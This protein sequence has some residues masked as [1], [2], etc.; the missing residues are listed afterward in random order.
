MLKK[1]LIGASLALIAAANT[2]SANEVNIYS[3]RQPFLIE[4]FLERFT[5]E[6]GIKTNVVFAKEGIFERIKT[7]GDLSPVDLV[8][9]VD[10]A[11]LASASKKHDLAQ[12]IISDVVAANIPAQFIG[13]DNAW[14]G[15]S[16]RVRIIATSK[17]RM[18]L[19][20]APKTYEDLADPQY[21]GKICIRSAKNIYNISLIA[22]MIAAH[23]EAETKTW[24]QG[25]KNNL[26]RKPQSNDRGQVQAIAE[27]VCDIA[28]LNNYYIGAMLEKADQKDWV[29]T[30]NITFPNQDDRGAHANVSGVVL[31]KSAPNKDNAMKLIEF[32][33]EDTAQQMYAEA[34]FEYPLKAD[35]QLSD[36]VASWGDYKTDSLEMSKLY[37]LREQALNLIDEVGFDD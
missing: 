5:Q 28:V 10:V 8:L 24:L 22:S 34:N 12:P 36:L 9:T 14:V 4:P 15:L 18:P 26:A 20:D 23:G 29:D 33:T 2:A 37:D 13:E 25:V 30:I 1:S 31:I 35:A 27:G 17:E 16:K 32:L 6:T 21:Q 3:Y 19:A 7:E 11:R